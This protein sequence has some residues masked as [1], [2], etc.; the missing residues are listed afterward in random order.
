MNNKILILV[1]MILG[2][3]LADYNLQG[4]ACFCQAEKI[5]ERKR[6]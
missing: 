6:S 2:H 1:A 5:L 3:I 4:V